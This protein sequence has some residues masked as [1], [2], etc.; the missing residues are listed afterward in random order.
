MLPR[1]FRPSAYRWVFLSMLF[2]LLSI[3]GLPVFAE[4]SQGVMQAFEQPL[5][6]S[7]LVEVSKQEK[8][9]ILFFMGITLLVGILTTAALGIAMGIY[10]KPVFV[11]HMVSAGLTVTLAI[12]HAIVAMVWF[13]PF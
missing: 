13:Y 9:Q 6:E 4:Q 10:A 2:A 5:E 8:H 1:L 12:I 11:A 7:D 3:T